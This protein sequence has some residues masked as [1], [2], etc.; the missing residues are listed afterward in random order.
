[1]S[2]DVIPYKKIVHAVISVDKKGLVDVPHAARL[3]YRLLLND[4]IIKAK[5]SFAKGSIELYYNKKGAEN[6]LPKISLDG[7]IALLKENGVEPKENGIKE[8]EVE[9]KDT[10]YNYAFEPKEIKKAKPY[11]W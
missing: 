4:A 3:Q 5:V 6:E 8:E 7:I 11:G 9:Y 10:L 1:M 2:M